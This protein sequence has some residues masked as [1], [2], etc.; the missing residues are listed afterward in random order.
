MLCFLLGCVGCL[1]LLG[2]CG[3][4]IPIVEYEG[5]I[6]LNSG[7]LRA[8]KRVFLIPV[9]RREMETWVTRALSGQ[10]RGEA[11]D[12][13]TFTWYGRNVAGR[14]HSTLTFGHASGSQR[15]MESCFDL[16]RFTDEAKMMLAKE[17]LAQLRGTGIQPGWGF[18]ENLNQS[19]IKF[20]SEGVVD[21]AWVE[22]FCAEFLRK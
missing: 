7:V 19:M 9:E 20:P 1:L 15:L 10:L 16:R 21:G 12:W 6:D 17:W 4:P 8:T 22:E 2:V 11:R 14:F 13:R 5:E 18:A 3:V